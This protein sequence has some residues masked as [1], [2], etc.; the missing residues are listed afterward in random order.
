MVELDIVL[1]SDCGAF[2]QL[3]TCIYSGELWTYIWL[4]KYSYRRCISSYLIHI[5]KQ[6][7]NSKYAW[8]H[9]KLSSRL[10]NFHCSCLGSQGMDLFKDW[11]VA[12]YR[13]GISVAVHYQ[14]PVLWEFSIFILLPKICSCMMVWCCCHL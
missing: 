11:C 3:L 14:P 12:W 9:F 13:W 5:S 8:L 1:H 4:Q 2:I 10:S 6:F 7:C